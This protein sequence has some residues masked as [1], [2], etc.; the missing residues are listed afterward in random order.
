QLTR[1]ELLR[2]D[3]KRV[4]R[5]GGDVEQVLLTGRGLDEEQVADV[6][7]R[8]VRDVANVATLQDE[9][10]D[11]LE[12]PPDVADRDD[13]G[14]LQLDLAAR[15]SQQ[16]ADRLLVDRLAAQDGRLVEQGE[17]VARRAFGSARDR[18]R[19]G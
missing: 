18:M 15:R 16:R 4:V 2:L 19:R 3:A 9:A 10:I 5:V 1:A 17:G 8:L 14:D 13:V 11:D 12:D 7:D 6:A